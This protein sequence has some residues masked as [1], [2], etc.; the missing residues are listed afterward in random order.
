VTIPGAAEADFIFTAGLAPITPVWWSEY[1]LPSLS[2]PRFLSR[3][4]QKLETKR[5]RSRTASSILI[6][7]HF[8]PKWNEMEWNVGPP[9]TNE[10]KWNVYSFFQEG[11]CNENKWN[12]KLFNE[13]S[14]DFNEMKKR[15]ALNEEKAPLNERKSL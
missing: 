3:V 15:H 11:M 8:T 12:K 6:N 1:T 13:I 5:H 9:P 2:L 4:P 14:L 10:M 7:I